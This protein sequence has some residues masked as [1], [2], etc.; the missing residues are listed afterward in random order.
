M[1]M[2]DVLALSFILILSLY[3]SRMCFNMWVPD[4]WGFLMQWLYI[5]S[6][7]HVQVLYGNWN[8]NNHLQISRTVLW[9]PALCGKHFWKC[10]DEQ[11]QQR[12]RR[13]IFFYLITASDILLRNSLRV[14]VFLE[15]KIMLRR[16]ITEFVIVFF[17]FVFLLSGN[18]WSNFISLIVWINMVETEEFF[19]F[20]F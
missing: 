9:A 20:S 2:F 12:K 17:I 3:R 7:Y 11:Q 19:K 1:R 8:V 16:C 6:Q 10:T 13:N 18:F 15:I 14:W 4:I 5:F